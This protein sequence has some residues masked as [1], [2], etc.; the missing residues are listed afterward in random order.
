MPSSELF[1]KALENLR[2]ISSSWDSN[3][4]SKF[5]LF[6]GDSQIF[7]KASEE[8]HILEHGFRLKIFFSDTLKA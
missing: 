2:T 7:S 5:R 6:V 8:S 3:K 1:L 4:P